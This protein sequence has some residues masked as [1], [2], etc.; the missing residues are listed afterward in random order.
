MNDCNL[1]SSVISE[2][3]V[4]D[5]EQLFVGFDDLMQLFA[6]TSEKDGKRDTIAVREQKQLLDD[7]Y[8][9]MQSHIGGQ[10][11]MR[12]FYIKQLG[13]AKRAVRSDITRPIEN[14]ADLKGLKAKVLK[15]IKRA[16]RGKLG[17]GGELDV[18]IDKTIDSVCEGVHKNF[19]IPERRLSLE[20]ASVDK[21]EFPEQVEI[22]DL[23]A[24]AE[25]LDTMAGDQYDL[26]R[27]KTFIE[28]LYEQPGKY[29]EL[30]SRM[31]ADAA[32][33]MAMTSFYD[34]IVLIQSLRSKL[35]EEIE[36]LGQ[37][38]SEV[39]E[40]CEEVVP[41]E[42]ANV[43]K[44]GI[45]SVEVDSNFVEA[46]R[47]FVFCH[48][49]G[50]RTREQIV[51]VMEEEYPDFEWRDLVVDDRLLKGVE[52][53]L[54]NIE[55][56]LFAAL[57]ELISK[58]FID[59]GDGENR[60][61]L[62]SKE[63]PDVKRKSKQKRKTRSKFKKGRRKAASD[64]SDSDFG[65]LM[66]ESDEVGAE[67]E[68]GEGDVHN[69][70]ASPVPDFDEDIPGEVLA[71]DPEPVPAES[72]SA[73]ASERSEMSEKRSSP[74][75]AYN[76]DA[77]SAAENGEDAVSRRMAIVRNK[78][79]YRGVATVKKL[80]RAVK[81]EASKPEVET[82]K[83]KFNVGDNVAYAGQGVGEIIRLE[84]NDAGF[85]YVLKM[86]EYGNILKI[87]VGSDSNDKLRSLVSKEDV[88]KIFEILREQTVDLGTQ[89]W[90]R[91]YR[92]MCDKLA[93]GS[94]LDHAELLRDLYKTRANKELSPGETTMLGKVRDIVTS[95]IAIVMGQSKEEVIK[96]IEAV[97]PQS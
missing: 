46:L 40:V 4:Q 69:M 89:T 24:C 28:T 8:E 63:E 55:P 50:N 74:G 72:E 34:R 67:D 43:L 71:P 22:D 79:R 21:I 97:F 12:S 88:K 76:P 27:L 53:L 32:F 1:E 42:E 81:I 26:D 62:E 87:L 86:A 61:D 7:G 18:I 2:E 73:E 35:K 91:R 41:A 52:N 29:S 66:Q 85:F 15:A 94:I 45:E 68:I 78:Q 23:K 6:T 57:D 39:E 92:A 48:I 20:G 19:F 58:Y 9:F 59:G 90:N 37:A 51:D 16:L 80:G 38:E 64:E 5:P 25:K 17:N 49:I 36:R 93:T 30:Y 44:E 65:A 56:D 14:R 13:S 75:V 96:E 83:P 77:F 11:R 70:E 47:R 3:W 31:A 95:Q 82:V 84:S 60:P 33:N 10:D 54:R